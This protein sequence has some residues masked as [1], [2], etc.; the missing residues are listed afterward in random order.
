MD[1]VFEISSF[2]YS[3]MFTGPST[4][5]SVGRLLMLLP[6]HRLHTHVAPSLSSLEKKTDNIVGTYP[7][8]RFV[9][10]SFTSNMHTAHSKAS[11]DIVLTLYC[12]R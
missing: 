5:E 4:F 7:L 2:F 8:K 9:V 3:V 10:V 12:L 6:T 1:T 11:K